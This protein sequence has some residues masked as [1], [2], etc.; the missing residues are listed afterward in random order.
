M[1]DHTFPTIRPKR[2][3]R[4][5]R[6]LSILRRRTAQVCFGGHYNAGKSTLLNMLL[7]REVLPTGALPETGAA[8]LITAGTADRIQIDGSDSA[9]VCEPEAL[10]KLG[11][12][13]DEA[14][15]RRPITAIPERIDIALADAPIPEGAVWIDAPGHNDDPAL[16]ARL[17]RLAVDSDVLVWVFNGRQQL[18]EPEVEFLR[19][20]I[21]RRGTAS[22]AFVVNV[23]LPTDD[24]A[25]WQCFLQREWPVHQRRLADRRVEL[26]LTFEEPPCFPVSARAALAE[27]GEGY[28]VAPLRAWLGE[29][30]GPNCTLVRLSRQERA[31]RA[32]L[33]FSNRIEPALASARAKHVDAEAAEAVYRDLVRRRVAFEVGARACVKAALSE[34]AVNVQVAAEAVTGLVSATNLKRDQT[35][36]T[37]L[38][39]ALQRDNPAWAMLRMLDNLLL[40]NELPV[41]T[42]DARKRLIQLCQ[43]PLQTVSVSD[44]AFSWPVAALG[45]KGLLA[46]G[47]GVLVSGP[48]ALL[49]AKA[50]GMKQAAEATRKEIRGAASG[51]AAALLEQE[52]TIQASVVEWMLPEEPPPPTP[53]AEAARRVR[54]L[55]AWADRLLPMVSQF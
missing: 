34:F 2:S 53:I 35:Y 17:M 25:A 38:N 39:A 21:D 16:S 27:W 6:T 46:G 5:P 37:E 43:P 32:R 54:R 50:V 18:A 12:I 47:V 20:F 49:A 36:E 55:E 11:S 33:H 9:V 3:A 13:Y 1:P 14:G 4:L 26:G 44:R 31:A 22:L 8:A 7:R 52:A 29:L 19:D 15:E 45:L 10:A 48:A 23:F 28:G 42:D 40:E 41:S 24:A 51:A 30:D